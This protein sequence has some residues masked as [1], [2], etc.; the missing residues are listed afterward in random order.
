MAPAICT[1]ADIKN[2]GNSSFFIHFSERCMWSLGKQSL[3]FIQDEMVNSAPI[4]K[5]SLIF[6]SFVLYSEAVSNFVISTWIGLEG[7]QRWMYTG[8]RFRKCIYSLVCAK[9]CWVSP[10]IKVKYWW[11]QSSAGSRGLGWSR[12]GPGCDVRD[13]ELALEG[14]LNQGSGVSFPSLTATF[15]VLLKEN[16]KNRSASLLPFSPATWALTL[17]ETWILVWPG[18]FLWKMLLNYLALGGFL[19]WALTSFRVFS[20]WF[21]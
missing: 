10:Y 17:L 12:R 6:N 5:Q 16:N 18:E 4:E 21:K 2:L 7:E 11:F 15:D 14:A 1:Q 13:E 20:H 3:V 8:C 19:H 9:R